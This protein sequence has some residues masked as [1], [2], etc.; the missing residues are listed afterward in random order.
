MTAYRLASGGVIDRSSTLSF[1][2]DGRAM[3]GHA[4]DT[5]ASAL[6]ANDQLLVG[7]SF[8]YH[9]PRGIVTAG[10]SEPNALVAIGKGAATDPNTKATVAELYAGF[11]ARSQNRW[12]SLK[13]DVGALNSL[14]SPFLSA[15]FYYKT[16]MWPA[17]FWEKVYEPLIRR[18]AGLGRAVLERDPDSYEKCWAHCDLL[19]VG[20]GP[21]GLMA[22]LTAGRA[23]LRVILADEDFRLGGSLLAET[24]RIDDRPAAD[25]AEACLAELRA[26]PNVTIMP[27]TTVFGWYDDNVFGAVERVQKHV[28]APQAKLPVERLWR[29]A[30][31]RAL[32]ATGAE[33]RPLVFGGNDRPGVMMAGAMRTYANRFGVAAGKSVAIFTNGSAGYRAA[34]DLSAHG[35]EV[36]AIVDSRAA[37]VDAAPAGVRVIQSASVIDTRGRQR[38][39]GLVVERSGFEETIAC[40]AIGMSGGWNPVI[41]LA[42][43]RGAKAVW[44][45]ELNTFL[46]PDVGN[47]FVVAGAAAGRYSLGGCLKDGAEKAAMIAADLGFSPAINPLPAVGE[48]ADPSFTPLWYSPGAKAKAFVDFQNDVHVKDLALALREGFGHVEHAKRYTTNG[49]ATDQ[50]KLSGINATGL[51][52]AMQGISPADVGTT[53]FRPFYTPVA[54]GA[55]AGTA[56]D[57]HAA[58]VRKSPLHGWAEKNG[59]VF[60]DSGLWYRP[61][62]FARKGEKT[63]RDSTDREVLNVRQNV[64]LCDVS[65]LGKIEIFGPDAA[66]FLNRLYCN[67]FLKLPVGKA[68][69]GLMLREDGLVYDDGTTSRLAPGHFFMTTTTALAGGVM[70][71][72][73]YC[74]QVLWPELK[75][76]FCSSSDQWAQMAIAGPKAR[77]V[78]QALLEDDISNAAFPFL[79][80]GVVTLKGGLK[81]RLFRISFSGEL[82][83]ELA[84]P[85]GFGEAVADAIMEEGRAHGICAYGL[86]ALNVLRIEKGHVTHAEFDGRVTPDDAGFGR[87][88][89]A[90]KPDFIG[91]RLSTRY[92]LTAADRMQMV[93]LKPVETDKLI[94]AGA[95]L[96][97]EGAKASTLND[98]GYVSSACFS[99]TLGHDIA[100]AFLKSGRERYGERIVVWDKLGGSETVAEVCSPVFVDPGNS[101]L[102]A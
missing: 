41:H 62:Y 73:E 19:V 89:S 93:G 91:K 56:R 54:L 48:E 61:A 85:A 18:A 44:S 21:T 3:K 96:L 6:L 28:A 59:A 50:G 32:L 24:M 9:R 5:L 77:L 100:L 43:Q 92:G 79:A 74:A 15:G 37:P 101:R 40:D 94:R 16:F 42:C 13:Y 80:A 84:V 57:E 52:A 82:A 72:M 95:H 87:M 102:N 70:S 99:P 46:A 69:Y 23:G 31:K 98:Q 78:V 53:T 1:K 10:P 83:Y 67:P 38:V 4:G 30:A 33:E 47:G 39:S 86:E 45:P 51:L 55:L 68:R 71:H 17:A 7:R 12:P 8:K 36:A 81:A 90:Q 14:L 65:T 25:F 75:V 27:R 20:S 22:A 60:V 26:L 49:M 11:D 88:V 35:V 64:G 34:S 66:E 2:F 76:R 29:I 63:W 97:R 58:P